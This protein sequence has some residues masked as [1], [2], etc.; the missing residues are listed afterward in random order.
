MR[1]RERLV[2]ASGS[3]RNGFAEWVRRSGGFDEWVCRSGGFV[4]VGLWNGFSGFREWRGRRS[5]KGRLAGALGIARQ[6]S[7]VLGGS[8][9]RSVLGRSVLGGDDLDGDADELP[10]ATMGATRRCFWWIGLA[11][12][13]SLS[14]RV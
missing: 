8:R 2:T 3:L 13:L 6:T 10:A 9:T 5:W 14:L 4:I 11:L 7:S 12:S 1:E